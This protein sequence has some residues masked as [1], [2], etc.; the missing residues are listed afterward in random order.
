MEN[1]FYDV[2]LREM[3]AVNSGSKSP[4]SAANDVLNEFAADRIY[5]STRFL[6]K[7]ELEEKVMKLKSYGISTASI[8]ERTG[9]SMRHVRRICAKL[10]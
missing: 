5:I 6:K 1:V 4:E 7:N 10:N 8:A 3:N 9:V 2:V